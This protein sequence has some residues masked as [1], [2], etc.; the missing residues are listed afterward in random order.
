MSTPT[1]STFMAT[2]TTTT[3]AIIVIFLLCSS[4][5][6]SSNTSNN[7]SNSSSN[8]STTSI[9]KP[10]TN[11]NTNN[12]TQD[13]PSKVEG[14]ATSLRERMAINWL[15]FAPYYVLLLLIGVVIGSI[16][17]WKILLSLFVLSVI[18]GVV[19][20][21][22]RIFKSQIVQACLLIISVELFFIV[23]HAQEVPHVFVIVYTLFP[24]VVILH[25]VCRR[26]ALGN[27]ENMK[28]YESLRFQL[29]DEL[30]EGGEDLNA[31]FSFLYK[32]D[33]SDSLLDQ[34]DPKKIDDECAH[35]I[36]ELVRVTDIVNQKVPLNSMLAQQTKELSRLSKEASELEEFLKS[37]CNAKDL[38]DVQIKLDTEV[39]ALKE[40]IAAIRKSKEKYE[41]DLQ[42][43]A[44]K[45][46]QLAAAATPSTPI[47]PIAP[48]APTPIASTPTASIASIAPT[49]P[50]Q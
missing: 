13:K 33:A 5:S 7:N 48:I 45:I 32:F 6:W 1:H 22:I 15:F 2:T 40:M 36:N 37:A 21:P 17:D 29:E 27:V 42:K 41:V 24:A 19:F 49:P 31:L 8:N 28:N 30:R 25:S 39:S 43:L 50:H 3:L 12:V 14:A 11:T 20:D 18:A 44:Q 38:K 16:L 34:Y 4:P 23:T 47:T 35:T 26:N 46:N 10:N 9:L